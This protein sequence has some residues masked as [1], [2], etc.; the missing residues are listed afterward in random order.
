MFLEAVLDGSQELSYISEVG[1]NIYTK[2]TKEPK[3][4]KAADGL[5]TSLCRPIDR[6]HPES[7]FSVEPTER[8]GLCLLHAI[9][10]CIE[11]LLILEV[12]NILSESHKINERCPGQGDSYRQAAFS[13]LE[14]I[15]SRRG[16]RNGNFR[17]LCNKAGAPKPVSLNRESALA[18]LHPETEEF[19]HVLRNVIP[20]ANVVKVILPKGV[21]TILNLRESYSEVDFVITLWASF[22][23]MIQILEKDDQP[24][25]EI[26]MQQFLDHRWYMKT[27]TMSNTCSTQKGFTSYTAS[28]MDLHH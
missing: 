22:F 26:T 5:R 24:K 7:L 20:G 12:C 6:P 8:I 28:D 16:V 23:T 1:W 2:C 18:I 17:I 3:G 15:I 21:M 4:D 9:T 27:V 10:R 11:K 14:A 19:P 13:N 25:M